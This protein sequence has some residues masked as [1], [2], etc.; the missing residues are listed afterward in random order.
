VVVSILSAFHTAIKANSVIP[1]IALKNIEY[2]YIYI[3]VGW[4]CVEAIIW[5]FLAIETNGR[6]LEEL[7]EIF[8]SPN[9]VKASKQRKIVAVAG[10]RVVEV[11]S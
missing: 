6:T 5:Y 7:E 10:D 4:D 1:A 11:G 2:K 3:F 8:A 9:P